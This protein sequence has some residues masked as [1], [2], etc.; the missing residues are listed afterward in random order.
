MTLKTRVIF[1]VINTE[2][3]EIISRDELLT[4][5]VERPSTID[6]IGLNATAQHQLAQNTADK[7]IEMQGPLIN[8]YT[9]C[10]RCE[11]KVIK[12]GKTSCDVHAMTTDHSIDI[13]KY[14]CPKCDWTSSDSIKTMYGTDTHTSL[15]KLQAELG[16]NYSYRKVVSILELM[17]S[18][19]TRPVNNKERIKRV[20]SEV[21]AHIGEYHRTEIL[22][23]ELIET[24]AELII[25]V[26]GAH[27]A[28]QEKSKRSFEVMTGTIYKPE[29]VQF[30]TQDKNVITKKTC[31]A[32]AKDDSQETMKQML[33][34][35]AKRAGMTK[36]TKVTGF[37]DG[38][39]N[40][41][42]VIKVLK[43]HC[44]E[45]ESILDWFHIS[46]KF[47]GIAP[48]LPENLRQELSSAKWKL[49]HG[50]PQDCIDKIDMLSTKIEDEKLKN[51]AM[52]FKNYIENNTEILVNYE[53]R[54]SKHLP[55]TSQVAESTVENLVN[56]RCRQTKKMQWLREGTHALLQVKCAHYCNSFNKIWEYVMPKLTQKY[57]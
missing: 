1:E 31:V 12:K 22:Q 24:S 41:K 28:T 56:S 11:H 46:M 6:D 10:P 15:T 4:L 26:D 33:L 35:A 21:G 13:Q 19:H 52:R 17:S 36:K 20:L 14:R 39:A 53:E 29:D 5:D 48:L 40:C 55:F 49:W 57:A 34:N 8:S 43:K 38:A 51:R 45:F 25:H 54:K 30:L 23:E 16:C 47:Q 27:V 9:T 3:G 7:M 44:G 2:T 37:S 50:L 18:G 42:S 32:S